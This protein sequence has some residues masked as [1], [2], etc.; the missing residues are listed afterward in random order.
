MATTSATAPPRARHCQGQRVGSGE[1]CR[2]RKH[3]NANGFCKYHEPTALQCRGT[4]SS[5]G[6][7][8]RNKWDL[9]DNQLCRFHLNQVDK[10]RKD[11][12]KEDKSSKDEKKK[13]ALKK[14]E[15]AKPQ[16]KAKLQCR[17]IAHKTSERCRITWDLNADEMC[18]YH[19][20]Q[21][22]KFAKAGKVDLPRTEVPE[23]S[24]AVTPAVNRR[25]GQCHGIAHS[26]GARCRIHWNLD[27]NGYCKYH[28]TQAIRA[29]I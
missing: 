23:V 9:N 7:R 21:V 20:R 10:V 2:I 3:L 5:T 27:A 14:E 25:G 18:Q 12:L 1:P 11:K 28:H 6:Q 16:E 15:P 4:A 29:R 26:T 13:E 24:V 17:G 8:C 19:H 22:P